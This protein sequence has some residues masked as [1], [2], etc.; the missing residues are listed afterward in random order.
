LYTQ[1]QVESGEVYRDQTKTPK[2]TYQ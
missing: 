2:N 1:G